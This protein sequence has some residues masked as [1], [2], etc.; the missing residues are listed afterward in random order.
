MTDRANLSVEQAYECAFRFVAQYAA[1]ERESEC[2]LLML[3]AMEPKPDHYKAN[4]PASWDDWQRC[5]RETLDG[6]HC[7][8][9]DR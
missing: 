9:I 1:R 4:D 6:P 8:R 7:R 5:V 2:L 3:V